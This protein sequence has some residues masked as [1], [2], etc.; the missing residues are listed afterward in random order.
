MSLDFI[1]RRKVV[2]ILIAL[3][4][5]GRREVYANRLSKETNVTYAHTANV[6][7]N[8]EALDLL[9]TTQDG[10]KKPIKLTEKGKEIGL[11]LKEIKEVMG[12]GNNN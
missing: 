12:D 6:I 3:V 11:R 8:L 4:S 9:E 5:N 10:R 1:L 7:K 2:E